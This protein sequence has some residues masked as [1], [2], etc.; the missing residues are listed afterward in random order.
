MDRCCGSCGAVQASGGLHVRQRTYVVVL[1]DHSSARVLLTHGFTSTLST[2]Q[3]LLP[4]HVIVVK[5]LSLC[6]RSVWPFRAACM[7]ESASNFRLIDPNETHQA[8]QRIC[9]VRLRAWWL[10]RSLEQPKQ[11]GE[12]RL[13]L[14]QPSFPVIVLSCQQYR[15]NRSPPQPQR[16]RE[17]HSPAGRNIPS[18][19]TCLD[20]LRQWARPPPTTTTTSFRCRNARIL[21]CV[22]W[23]MHQ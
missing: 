16:R 11:K 14:A 3:W 6:M 2:P 4:F 9:W 10:A 7:R 22:T 18:M 19:H 1:D 17:V 5:H 21:L 20:L 12:Q 8:V 13:W 23:L 15:E